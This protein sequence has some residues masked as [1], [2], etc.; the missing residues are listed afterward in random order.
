MRP[1]EAFEA[2]CQLISDRETWGDAIIREGF[3]WPRRN[4][5]SVNFK[6]DID[7]PSE[8]FSIWLKN[9]VAKANDTTDGG[10]QA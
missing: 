10:D 3:H 4:K 1:E 2:L 9:A 8:V 7:L 5:D 6:F